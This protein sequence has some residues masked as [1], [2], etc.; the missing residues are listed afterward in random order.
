[1]TEPSSNDYQVIN[2]RKLKKGELKIPLKDVK[3]ISIK[4]I[5]LEIKYIL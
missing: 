3:K 4:Q 2:N 5:F 1:M